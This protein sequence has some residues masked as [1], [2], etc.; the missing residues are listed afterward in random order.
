MK[1][2]STCDAQKPLSEFYKGVYMCPYCGLVTDQIP[3]T[4]DGRT[5][6]EIEH[7]V[8]RSRGGSNNL[9]NIRVV[10]WVCNRSKGAKTLEEWLVVAGRMG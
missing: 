1:T 9:E 2:C 8:P 4:S 7:V 10:C 3:S 6:W 5:K